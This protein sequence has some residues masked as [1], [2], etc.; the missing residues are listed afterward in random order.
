M[1]RVKAEPLVPDRWA[2]F[3]W[4]PVDDTDPTDGD[5]RLAFEWQ[6]AHVNVISHSASEIVRRDGALHCS[7]MYRHDT[8]TQ[9]LLV[10]DCRA[11]IAVAPASVRFDDPAEARLVRA[12]L[13]EPLHSL[14]LHRGTWHWGPFP[15]Q[16]DTVHLF[17]V[18][19]H[20][21][22]EDNTCAPL[23]DLGYDIEVEL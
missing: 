7:V 9:V 10:L 20:R 23:D 17:N 4:L 5:H 22:L 11:V 18:Q 14:V 16:A 15:V 1:V 3:G 8:H 2:S 21:Y 13:I 19:G 12:F 6:D